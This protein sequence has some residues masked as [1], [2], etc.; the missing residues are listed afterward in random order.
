MAIYSVN[1][2]YA[3]PPAPGAKSDYIQREGQV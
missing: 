3:V 2:F 1:G